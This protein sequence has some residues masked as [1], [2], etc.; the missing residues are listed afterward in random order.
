MTSAGHHTLHSGAR[1]DRSPIRGS[2][3]LSAVFATLAA[4]VAV[5][6][7]TDP[8]AP[9]APAP[10]E[11]QRRPAPEPAP[12]LNPEPAPR[13]MAPAT[14]VALDVAATCSHLVADL[15]NLHTVLLTAAEGEVYCL[16]GPAPMASAPQALSAVTFARDALGTPYVWGGNGRRDGGYDCSG[17][18]TAAYA[19]AGLHLPRTAQRQYD[20]IPHLAPGVPTQPGDLVFFGKGPRSVTHVGIA[21]SETLMINAPRRGEVVKIAPLHRADLVGIARPSGLVPGGVS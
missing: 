6:H 11:M 20:E 1:R 7:S 14:V 16:R 2:L 21:V 13:P 9:R 10:A 19:A 4:F 18:T 3:A 12:D 15:E 8:G 5:S 17:L